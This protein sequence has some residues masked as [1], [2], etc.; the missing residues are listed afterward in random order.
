MLALV[1]LCTSGIAAA[2]LVYRLEIEAPADMAEVLRQGLNIARW[3]HDPQMT[4]EQL[5]R[6]AAEAVQEAREVAAT[7]GYFSAQVEV[8]IDE[9]LE[10]WIVSL[11]VEPGE[12]TL[13]GE[14][15]L[16]FSGPAVA[17]EQARALLRRVRE[18]W[19]L[20]R[21]QPF[22]QA[23]W[24][25]AK[26]RAVQEMS[27]W[28]YATA[29]IAASEARIDPAARRARLTVELASGPAHRFG[30]VRVSGTRRYADDVARNL[31]P[32]RPGDDY[33]H[34]ALLLYQRRLLESGYFVSVQ[35][36]LAAEERRP[37][38]SPVRVAVIEAPKHHVEAGLGYNTDVGPRLELR[39]SNQDVLDS[40]WRLRSGLGLDRKIQNLQLD[41]DSPPRPGGRWTSY[42]ARARQTDIQNQFTRELAGGGAINWGA[43]LTPS[44][45]ILSGH[46][47]EQRV[48]GDLTDNRHAVYLGHRRTFRQTDDFLYPRSG[49]MAM[50][51]LGGA[52]APLASRTFVRGVVSGSWFLPFGRRGDLL[53]RG[54]AGR[55][56]AA[57]REGIPT[58][59]LFRTGG[60]QTVRGYAFESLGVRQGDAI[61]GGRRF[62]VTSAEYTHWFG[63]TWGI[64]GFVDAGNAWDGGSLLRAAVGSGIGARFRTPIGPIRADLAYGHETAEIR[65][66]F[67]VG[68]TF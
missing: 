1:L 17:D 21:G 40:A 63:E 64:A 49:Y 24:D 67:S 11:T 2:Q 7:E 47:E 45:L 48:A 57:S 20:R 60:D 51:E 25:A 26:Q 6:L 43:G 32:F 59:F 56:L 50:I 34:D 37:E 41:L 66:H 53:L 14:V 4:A 29:R 62:V 61:V 16:R 46:L 22:R 12:R 42:F 5:R 31:A 58:S 65:L 15:D 9:G 23:D 36:D 52:P 68:Y 35:A 13:V 54:Q 55:V 44:S 10:P 28:R 39:Y 3:Q 19:P 27:S 30:E 8:S 38:G 33:D 18:T